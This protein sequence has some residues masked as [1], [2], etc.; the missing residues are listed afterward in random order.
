MNNVGVRIRERRRL[1]NLGQ[2]QL[3]ARIATVTNG[4][5]SPGWQDLSRIENG[6]R[7]VSDLEVVAVA[8]ALDCDACW[9][10]VGDR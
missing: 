10:L 9:L 4:E 6:D 8:N 7:I 3:C 1:L 5:W 2:D